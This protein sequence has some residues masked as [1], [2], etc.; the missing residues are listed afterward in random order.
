MDDTV[1]WMRSLLITMINDLHDILCTPEAVR[2]QPILALYQPYPSASSKR[3]AGRGSRTTATVSLVSNNGAHNL[4][5]LR[6]IRTQVSTPRQQQRRLRLWSG[7]GV[8]MPQSASWLFMHDRNH[9]PTAG[10]GDAY[11]PLGAGSCHGLVVVLPSR[12]SSSAILGLPWP[13]SDRLL[14]VLWQLSG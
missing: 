8:Q 5:V 3:N 1:R 12:Q 13:K 11:C 10:W 7:T 14:P 9:P 2:P 4:S 6:T